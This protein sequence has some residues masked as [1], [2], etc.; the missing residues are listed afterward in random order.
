MV[1]KKKVTK[2]RAVTHKCPS[3]KKVISKVAKFCKNCGHD[4]VP[5]K[6]KGTHRCPSC[7]GMIEGHS[8]YCKH[9]GANVDTYAHHSFVRLLL[10]FIVFLIAASAL[11]LF[12]SPEFVNFGVVSQEVVEEPV[13]PFLKMGSA[14]CTWKDDSFTLCANVN[15]DG[16]DGDYVQCSFSGNTDGKV[17]SSSPLT[18][19]GDVGTNEGVKLVRSFLFDKEG[20]TYKDEAMSVNCLGK[21]SEE[22]LIPVKEEESLFIEKS[23]W[24]TAMPES[25]SA[26][27]EDT[28]SFNFDRNVRNCEL[29]GTWIT[30]RNGKYDAECIGAT[31]S[32]NAQADLFAQTVLDNP[33]A[34]RWSG[35]RSDV[36]DPVAQ[37]Y[38]GEVLHTN[39]CDTNYNVQ[40]KNMVTAKLS[41]FET[42]TLTYE[43]EYV[44]D[45][46]RPHLDVFVD[47]SCEVY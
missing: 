15:W 32:F 24:F 39:L 43:W 13:E 17:W 2:K 29:S 9:C 16:N 33:G 42:K 36:L 45:Y 10:F 37:A 41:G 46:P 8:R 26:S 1:A 6:K 11:L 7:K 31:G 5:H 35:G 47:M 3:C 12:Y 30:T 18:C 21:T 23:F 4:I 19:C 22:S 25:S 20:N 40:S 14:V 27:G 44:S 34:F 38:S 28:I